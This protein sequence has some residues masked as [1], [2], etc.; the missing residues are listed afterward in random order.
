MPEDADDGRVN[1]FQ[2]NITI[3][4]R[5]IMISPNKNPQYAIAET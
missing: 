4:D 1:L 2:K 5:N 3:S